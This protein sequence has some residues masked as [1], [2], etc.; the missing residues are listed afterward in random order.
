[1]WTQ[2]RAPVTPL[3]LPALD[4]TTTPN[5]GETVAPRFAKQL[6]HALGTSRSTLSSA[7]AYCT[8]WMR[9]GD[10]TALKLLSPE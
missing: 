2:S 6:I 3:P 7:V 1:M 5:C 8:V 4:R 9:G 10:V